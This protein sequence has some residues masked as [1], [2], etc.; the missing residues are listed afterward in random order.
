MLAS[1]PDPETGKDGMTAPNR[2]QRRN[3]ASPDTAARARGR[4]RFDPQWCRTCR[5]CE[6]ACSIAKEGVA[7]PAVAGI[8]IHFD[9]FS[10]DHPVSAT[11]CLQCP[12]AP[13]IAACPVGAMVRDSRTGAVRVL[14]DV[15]IGCMLCQK[16]CPWGVP[17]RHP[18]RRLAVKCDLCS[19]RADGPQCVAMCPLA[20]K[21][22]IYEPEAYASE[23]ADEQP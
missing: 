2:S 3:E 11:L 20:G 7:R 8:A 4:I 12:D 19:D 6:I 1:A 17:Q 22:L 9:E 16:A 5:V 21:A 23:V 13:C 14:E 10:S 18:D 15:C